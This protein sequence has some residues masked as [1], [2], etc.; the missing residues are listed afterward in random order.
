MPQLEIRTSFSSRG[1][2]IPPT[3][4]HGPYDLPKVTEHF[5]FCVHKAKP[6]C[7]IRRL[8]I[9]QPNRNQSRNQIFIHSNHSVM[10]HLFFFSRAAEIKLRVLQKRADSL[11]SGIGWESGLSQWQPQTLN[12][13]LSWYQEHFQ[14]Q[15][16]GK[17]KGN[18]DWRS[19]SLTPPDTTW[20]MDGKMTNRIQQEKY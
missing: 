6:S 19:P 14:G 15:L 13:A 10:K 18:M 2:N 16:Q 9:Y 11:L 17:W 20:Q 3:N 12:K 8:E 4:V 7:Q 1:E 5:E